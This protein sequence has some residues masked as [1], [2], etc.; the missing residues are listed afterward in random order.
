[1]IKREANGIIGMPRTLLSVEHLNP[2]TSIKK[3]NENN[4]DLTNQNDKF[5]S[6]KRES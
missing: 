1:M 2:N 4:M 3:E 5:A 6:R